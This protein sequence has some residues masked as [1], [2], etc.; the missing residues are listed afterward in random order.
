M[1]QASINNRDD[2]REKLETI[3]VA[4]VEYAVNN[5]AYYRV[6]FSDGL[7]N[8]QKYPKLEQL[9]EK[10]FKVLLD[11]I[12]AGQAAQIFNTEDSRQLACV[13][14]SLVHGVSMLAIDNQL[15]ISNPAEIVELAKVAT[16]TVSKGMIK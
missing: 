1:Q 9:S 3:G 10:A 15:M 2:V 4:H 13:C 14:W 5:Q 7:R 11:T 6:M 12:E 8:S 16:K